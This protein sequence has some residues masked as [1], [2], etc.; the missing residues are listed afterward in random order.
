V[1]ADGGALLAALRPAVTFRNQDVRGIVRSL[2]GDAGTDLG[3]IDVDL[4]LAA[5][6]ADQRRTSAEHV[7]NLAELAGAIGFVDGDGRLQVVPRPAAQADRAL[8]HGREFVEYEVRRAKARAVA[9][10]AGNGPSGST[11][12]P[13][14]L[15]QGDAAL[16]EDAPRPGAGAIWRAAAVLRTPSAASAALEASAKKTAAEATLLYARCWLLPALRA[17]QVVEIQELPDGVDAGP[18]LLTRVTHRLHPRHGATT[19]IE[20]VSAAAAGS[21]LDSLLGAALGAVGGLL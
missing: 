18:W 15:Q 10:P 1:L 19:T 2:A 17:G 7:A 21:L 13:N 6:V 4:S 16:P 11:D 20:A 14:A 5:Y 12:A 8:K 9:V 3:T